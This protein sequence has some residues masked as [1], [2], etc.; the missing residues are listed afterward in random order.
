LKKIFLLIVAD[1]IKTDRDKKSVF[2][3]QGMNFVHQKSVK[4]FDKQFSLA[5]VNVAN[6]NAK[7]IIV[8]KDR[9]LN[10]LGYFEPRPE[11]VV[12]DFTSEITCFIPRDEKIIQEFPYFVFNYKN[13]LPQEQVIELFISAED[14]KSGKSIRIPLAVLNKFSGEVE[15]KLTDFIK[16][17]L[18]INGLLFSL[19]RQGVS[20]ESVDWYEFELADLKFFGN[21]TYSAENKDAQS[22]I[23]SSVALINPSLVKIDSQVFNFNDFDFNERSSLLNG[24]ILKKDIFL[25][26]QK[27]SYERLENGTFDL[28]WAILE[29]KLSVDIPVQ[30]LPKAR[31]SFTKINPTKYLVH[32]QGAVVPFWIV[33]NENFSPKWSLYQGEKNEGSLAGDPKRYIEKYTIGDI[34]Y[35]LR[36]PLQANHRIVNGYANGWY[37]DPE[38]LGFPEDFTLVIYY[39]SQSGIYLSFIVSGI[40]ILL[41]IIYLLI[42]KKKNEK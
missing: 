32:I 13:G 16:E 38:K 34:K 20:R 8:S 4:L 6:K 35:V 37:V 15:I 21:L 7:N 29:P 12:G 3:L 24:Y 39:S 25:S 10:L 30:N 17:N 19:K 14:I 31:V 27:H 40:S 18:R 23:N 22:R 1:K 41:G 33:F 26:G 5:K 9:V 36:K 2:R 42:G 28:E 11:N